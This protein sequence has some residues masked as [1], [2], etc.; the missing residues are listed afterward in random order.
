VAPGLYPPIKDNTSLRL[1]RVDSTGRGE[2]PIK[3][4]CDGIWQE[5]D[6]RGVRK[7][8]STVVLDVPFAVPVVWLASSGRLANAD[9]FDAVEGPAGVGVVDAI[10]IAIVLLFCSDG[11]DRRDSLSHE[12]AAHTLQFSAGVEVGHASRSHSVHNLCHLLQ[13]RFRTTSPSAGLRWGPEVLRSPLSSDPRVPISFQMLPTPSRK[14]SKGT[15]ASPGALSLHQHGKT[16]STLLATSPECAHRDQPAGVLVA[17]IASVVYPQK[18]LRVS[19]GRAPSDT[20]FHDHC[21]T[22]MT[23]LP[24]ACCCP[25]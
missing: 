12:E 9:Y 21:S 25:K 5:T 24:C 23:I 16:G 3:E 11:R 15:D 4:V 17:G 14:P 13:R 6:A 18:W 8:S 2:T 20:A 19:R 7:C 1:H 10:V 22:A